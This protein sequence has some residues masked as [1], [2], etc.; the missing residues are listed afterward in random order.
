MPDLKKK[1]ELRSVLYSVLSSARFE[2]RH[3]KALDSGTHA[4]IASKAPC[5]PLQ[6]PRH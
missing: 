4:L 3:T 2:A 6:I 1:I 5:L